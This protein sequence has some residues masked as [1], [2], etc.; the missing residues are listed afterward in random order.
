MEIRA[1]FKNSL[2][3]FKFF[4]NSSQRNFSKKKLSENYCRKVFK[5][6]AKKASFLLEIFF[7]PFFV[8]NISSI[9]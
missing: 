7:W 8:E 3:V 4:T 1:N 5:T 2:K 6:S 9:F